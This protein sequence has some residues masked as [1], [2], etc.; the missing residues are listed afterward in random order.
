ME[1]YCELLN[2]DGVNI[3]A[4]T[5]ALDYQCIHYFKSFGIELSMWKNEA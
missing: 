1:D 2:I 3:V 4:R 5:D